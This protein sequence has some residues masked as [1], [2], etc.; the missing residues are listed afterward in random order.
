[1]ID[2]P[3]YVTRQE[4]EDRIRPLE[5]EVTGEKLVT[6]H[7]LEHTR[8]NGDDLASLKD[9]MVLVQATL[10]THGGRLTLLTQDVTAMRTEMT[11]LR[12]DVGRIVERLDRLDANV[13]QMRGDVAAIRAAVAPREPPGD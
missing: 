3:A 1:M 6:R 2:E 12:R 7:I 10:L 13:D 8:R 11:A 5:N 9:A 4:F